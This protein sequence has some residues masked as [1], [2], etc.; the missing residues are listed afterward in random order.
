[1][2]RLCDLT[3]PSVPNYYSW[4]EYMFGSTLIQCLLIKPFLHKKSRSAEQHHAPKKI[5]ALPTFLPPG[6]TNQHPARRTNTQ[7][8]Y[9]HP[10]DL[11]GSIV[12]SPIT[13]ETLD[14]PATI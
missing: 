11:T 1:M 8:A 3:T 13:P 9:L 7:P 12:F 14:I 6:P 2:N 4:R 5:P 10:M